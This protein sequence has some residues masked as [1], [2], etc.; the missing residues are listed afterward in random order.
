ML[1]AAQEWQDSCVGRSSGR[2]TFYKKGQ[3]LPGQSRRKSSRTVWGQK[4]FCSPRHEEKEENGKAGPSPVVSSGLETSTSEPQRA[5]CSTSPLCRGWPAWDNDR[6]CVPHET[7]SGC[8]L[9]RGRM[10][11]VL[12]WPKRQSGKWGREQAGPKPPPSKGQVAKRP[13]ATVPLC[14]Y[15]PLLAPTQDLACQSFGT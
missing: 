14:W 12:S 10:A 9:P 3:Q 15:Q 4:G 6:K 5:V 13:S 1:A 8:F 2:L 7:Q 11:M